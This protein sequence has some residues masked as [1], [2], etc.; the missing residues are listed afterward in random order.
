MPG[1]RLEL[2]VTFI[3]PVLANDAGA[4]ALFDRDWMIR[5]EQIGYDRARGSS[6]WDRISPP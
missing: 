4:N 6:P 2:H 1:L 5:L 3:P